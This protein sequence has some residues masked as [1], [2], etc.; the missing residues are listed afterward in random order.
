MGT[1]MTSVGPFRRRCGGALVV[2]VLSLVAP[3][4]ALG[5]LSATEGVQFSGVVGTF[6]EPCPTDPGTNAYVCGQLKP[7]ATVAWGDGGSSTGS[8]KQDPVS[9]TVCPGPTCRFAVSG[10]YTYTQGTFAG[11]PYAG[12][13]T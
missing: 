7:T 2:A 6:T 13:I 3:G 8:V 10:T 5:D 11:S 9:G 4:S 1:P 12:T